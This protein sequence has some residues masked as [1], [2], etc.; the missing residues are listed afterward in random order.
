LYLA[1][2]KLM[3]KLL[4][5]IGIIILFFSCS[6]ED[7]DNN[8]NLPNV[9]V[10]ETIF[11]NNPEFIDLNVVGGWAYAQGGITGIVIYHSSSNIYVAFERSAP[12]LSP[13]PCSIMDV[14]NSI[15]MICSCDESE[16]SIL[17]GSPQTDGIKYAAR[18]YKVTILGNNTLHITNF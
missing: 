10:N 7:S 9:N 18:Q 5:S 2:K 1:K 17:D 8:T 6:S 3:K 11:L 15:K 12:H 16:F 4:F 14:R 13:Q